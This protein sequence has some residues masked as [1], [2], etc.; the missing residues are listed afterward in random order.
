MA[1]HWLEPLLRR[2]LRHFST[3]HAIVQTKAQKLVNSLG[4]RVVVYLTFTLKYVS[5]LLILFLLVNWSLISLKKCFKRYLELFLNA[6]RRMKNDI[7]TI[8]L[9]RIRKPRHW[10]TRRVTR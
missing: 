7:I 9:W 10:S 6:L 2:M 8:S 1:R 4:N 5:T 3:E